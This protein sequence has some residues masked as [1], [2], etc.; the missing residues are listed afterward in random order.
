MKGI[1]PHLYSIAL[2]A[3]ML[4]ALS[5]VAA[6][7]AAQ[8]DPAA[9]EAAQAAWR[10]SMAHTPVPY[11]GCFEVEYPGTNWSPVDCAEAP[12]VPY[13]P[14][15]EIGDTVGN[16][17]DYAAGTSKVMTQSIGAFGTITGVTS[18]TGVN[19][20]NDYSLQLNSNTMSTA[21]CSGGAAGC[22]TWQQFVYASHYKSAFMQ[23]WLIGYVNPCPSGWATFGSDCYKNSKAVTAPQVGIKSL[24]SLSLTGHAVKGGNDTL[25]FST[26]SKSYATTGKDSVLHLANAWKHAEFNVIGDGGGSKAVFNKGSSV[27]VVVFVEDGSTAA[28]AC[29]SHAGTTG[30]TNNLTLGACTASVGAILI[31]PSIQFTESN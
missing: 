14:R 26:A 6:P 11:E 7:A 16:G 8:D 30:E 13:I 3:G 12:D 21:A 1:P 2:T 15:G 17:N 25:T 23:Y 29:L 20:A 31:P 28:P 18:E 22:K 24:G 5:V 4:G 27:D 19:G 10:M 9:L